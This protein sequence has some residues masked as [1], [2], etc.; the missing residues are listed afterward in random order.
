[1]FAHMVDGRVF[2]SVEDDTFRKLFLDYCILG[3][4]P[5][6]VE[7]AVRTASFEGSLATQRQL[8]ADYRGDVMKYAQ[9]LNKARILNVFNSI[10]AQ[11]AKENKEFQLSKVEKGARFK[12]YQ[13]CVEW[14]EMARMVNVCWCL[15]HP[16]LPFSGNVNEKKYKLYVADIGLLVALL[17]EEA[18][19]DLRANKNLGVHKGAL[20]ESFA[21]EALS[22]CGMKLYYYYKK[23]NSALEE[24]FF[25]RTR[26]HLVPIEVKASRNT[27]KSLRTL[28]AS[29]AYPDIAFGLKFHGGNVGHEG[30]VYAFPCYCTFLAKRYLSQL[31]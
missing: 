3:G 28:I 6:V 20:Y 8:I 15:S 26:S 11:L 14:L 7:K 29:D 5:A 21:A 23:E 4:M 31:E 25:A 9:G 1:M 27:A 12:D 30:G 22:K 13:G 24:D 19:E 16:E 10:P 17:D 2:S 18:S